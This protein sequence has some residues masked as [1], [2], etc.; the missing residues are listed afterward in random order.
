MNIETSLQAYI[1]CLE[2]SYVKEAMRY[3]LMAG[4]KRLRPRLVLEIVKGYGLSEEIGMPFACALEMIHTYSLIHD[5]LPSMDNDDLR[6]GK[7]TCHKQFDEATAILAGDALLTYAFEVLSDSQCEHEII[8]KCVKILACNAGG[9]GMVLGQT[10][11]IKEGE[12]SVDWQQLKRIH[13]LKTGCLLASACMMG[14]TI[15]KQSDDVVNK[16]K[17]VGFMLGLAFQIQDDVMDVEE[18]EANLGKSKSDEKNHKVTSV[19]LLGIDKAK[20][21]LTTLY[22]QA[23]E[24]IQTFKGFDNTGLIR[25]INNLIVRKY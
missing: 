8:R 25:L 13:E 12:M 21:M 20:E 23:Q 15:A 9:K 19:T 17:D 14:S 16:W 3:S 5:D 18:S 22:Q 6:R 2:D 7:P 24:T 4:G 10:F 1:D 11:D